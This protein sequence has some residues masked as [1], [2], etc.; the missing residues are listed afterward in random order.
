MRGSEIKNP[1]LSGLSIGS[2]VPHPS[3]SPSPLKKVEAMPTKKT[4]VLDSVE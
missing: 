2:F 4:E 3:S 1:T